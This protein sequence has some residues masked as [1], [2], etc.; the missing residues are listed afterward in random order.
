MKTVQVML[1][2]ELLAEMDAD[3][4]VKREGRSAFL[5]RSA[6]ELLRQRRRERIADAYRR[7]YADAGC[8][9]RTRRR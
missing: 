6:R 4:E 7:G 8:R 3:E 9:L 1:D 5:R 2:E